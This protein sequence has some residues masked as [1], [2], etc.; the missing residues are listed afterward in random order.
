MYQPKFPLK[1][2]ERDGAYQSINDLTESVKQNVIFLLNTSPGEWPGRPNFGIGVRRFL[3]ENVTSIEWEKLHQR[4][5]EQF[6]KYMPFLDVKSEII[7]EGIHG[8]SLID[9][10]TVKLVLRYSINPI[11]VQDVVT[12]NLNQKASMQ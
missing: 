7:T 8:E 9:E 3:F 1:M 4:I 6:N 12:L 11:S 5:K 10:N 2:S